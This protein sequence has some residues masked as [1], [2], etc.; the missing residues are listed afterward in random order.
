MRKVLVVDDE[1]GIVEILESILLEAGYEVETAASGEEGLQRVASG[2]PDAVFLD[3]RMPS[4]DGLDLMRALRSEP[5]WATI[6][7][8]VMSSLPEEAVV[9]GSGYTAFLRKPFRV[10]AVLAALQRALRRGG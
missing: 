3:L 8:V 2:A 1:V 7:V 4:L 6:P 5:A 9:Q 10:S